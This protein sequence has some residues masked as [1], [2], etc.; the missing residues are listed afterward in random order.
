MV[1]LDMPDFVFRPR[2]PRLW[3]PARS[4][5]VTLDIRIV[6]LL[7]GSDCLDEGL[8]DELASSLLDTLEA[9]VIELPH[10]FRVVD[11]DGSLGRGD[12]G[13]FV[14]VQLAPR[15][16]RPRPS[17]RPGWPSDTRETHSPIYT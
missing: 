8:G 2:T 7:L 10:L 15:N 4:H 13:R 1:G 12:H 6:G 11:L 17:P 9:V 3:P 5:G 14:I 16:V